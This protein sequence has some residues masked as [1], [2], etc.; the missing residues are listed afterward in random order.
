MVS[1]ILKGIKLSM[2]QRDE[3]ESNDIDK[4]S[5]FNFETIEIVQN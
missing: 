1:G 3:Y 5:I 4:P 2:M